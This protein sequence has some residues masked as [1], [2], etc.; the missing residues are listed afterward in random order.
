MPAFYPGEP[1]PQNHLCL[2]VRPNTGAG[3]YTLPSWLHIPRQVSRAHVSGNRLTTC[4][5]GAP[6]QASQRPQP[7]SPPHMSCVAM[8]C[9]PLPC[10]PPGW[11]PAHSSPHLLTSNPLSSPCCQAHPPLSAI[12]PW[13]VTYRNVAIQSPPPLP[14]PPSASSLPYAVVPSH[15][16]MAGRGEAELCCLLSPTLQLAQRMLS[17]EAVCPSMPW[18]SRSF[19]GVLSLDGTLIMTLKSLSSANSQYLPFVTESHVATSQPIWHL[20]VHYA[21]VFFFPFFSQNG[22]PCYHQIR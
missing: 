20:A 6:G 3:F 10:T 13:P 15:P 17:G 12:T 19:R 18:H 11:C 5:G 21:S 2:S 22:N 4:T 7:R 9:F 8:L 16:Q 1:A 14:Q